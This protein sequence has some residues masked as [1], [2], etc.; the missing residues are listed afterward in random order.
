ML[1]ITQLPSPPQRRSRPGSAKRARGGGALPPL[2]PRRRS[3]GHLSCSPALGPVCPCELAGAGPG[4]RQSSLPFPF[5]HSDIPLHGQRLAARESPR[6]PA[7]RTPASPCP[8]AAPR[9]H[10]FARRRQGPRRRA[11]Q[12]PRRLRAQ[13]A[14]LRA[15][16]PS[17]RG[18][19]RTTG[20]RHAGTR[21][22]ASAQ[23][24]S[25]PKVTRSFLVVRR[26]ARAHSGSLPR[27]RQDPPDPWNPHK[28]WRFAILSERERP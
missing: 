17:W 20:P 27:S 4:V 23:A 15:L 19:D 8:P 3:L 6:L 22:K 5:R 25:R 28:Q 18:L 11:A 2:A 1:P 12:G 24:L 21:S 13:M 10:P 14:P 26:R 9:S 7:I 16:V